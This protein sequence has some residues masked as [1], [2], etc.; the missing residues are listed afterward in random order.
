VTQEIAQQ[1]REQSHAAQRAR[2]FKLNGILRAHDVKGST[3]EV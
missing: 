3:Q 1:R 2:S